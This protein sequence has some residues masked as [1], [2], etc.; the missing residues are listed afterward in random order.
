MSGHTLADMN[1][2]HSAPRS[3]RALVNATVRAVIDELALIDEHGWADEEIW[4]EDD[5]AEDGESADPAAIL[6][7]SARFR[8]AQARRREDELERAR[9][10]GVLDLG[11]TAGG[12]SP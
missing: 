6:R 11:P 9:F 4:A 12:G 10:R 8:R 2:N 7:R 5:W 1:T 3:D